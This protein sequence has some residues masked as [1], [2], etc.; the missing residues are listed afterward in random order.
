MTDPSR[1]LPVSHRCPSHQWHRVLGAQLESTSGER[2][3]V[4]NSTRFVVW[5]PDAPEVTVDIIDGPQGV[6]L[7]RCDDGYHLAVVSD[8]PAGS[9]YFYRID[10]GPQRPDP[11]SRFQ[12]QGVHGPSEVID[13]RFDWSDDEWQLP[14]R[15][16]WIIYEVHLGTFT[17]KG[18]FQS[19][20]ERLDELVELG[21]T[22]IELMPVA[23]SA[24]R[25]NWGYDGVALFAPAD[26]Y[27]TP[28]DFRQFVNAAHRKGLAVF[29]DVVY[30]HL[31]PEGNYLH[32]FGPYFSSKHT[33]VWGDAPNFD[34]PVHGDAVRRFVIA[35]AVY[36]LEEFHLDGLRVDAIH[37][38]ADDREPHVAAEISD[39]VALW[40]AETGREGALIAESNV[41]DPTMTVARSDGGF[42]FDAM[43]S[44]CFLHSAFATF[45]PGEPLCDRPYT[46]KQ[47]LAHVLV[48]GYVYEG[49]V[50]KDRHRTTPPSRVDP[51]ELIYSIQNHD[52][53]GNHPLGVRLHQLMS[54]DAH[55]A[56]AALLL[57]SPAIP[58]LFMGEE[59]A[60][61][62]PFRFFVDFTDPHL[63]QCVID[64]R[65]REYPQHNWSGGVLPT[66]PAAFQSAKIGSQQDGN[67]ETLHW[68]QQLIAIRKQ[69]RMAGLLIDSNLQT[70]MQLEKDLYLLRYVNESNTLTVAA[71]LS[72][73]DQVALDDVVELPDDGTVMLHSGDPNK[74]K[75]LAPNQAIV[76]LS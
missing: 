6:A 10:G 36:W 31:G 51:T 30:N 35:N 47:D 54:H 67:Q 60:S 65:Q 43:W 68:Y 9:R 49:T 2:N 17:E 24:G 14:P 66:D 18:T 55:R 42:G 52:F 33:T 41:Y 29:L 59:F 38:M 45:R 23:A 34:D 69:Y 75:C 40:R 32:D 71:R 27:G 4:A 44:D 11:V 5:A 72:S 62:N 61:E 76:L 56:A 58:M 22:A 46:S 13:H 1:A 3:S 20:I 74:T 63:R 48:H 19:A 73:A 28:D 21:V 8:V 57:L 39:A 26:G 25:W 37:C 53:I 64:G 70:E 50:R 12:P 16:Q 7:Q 15:D